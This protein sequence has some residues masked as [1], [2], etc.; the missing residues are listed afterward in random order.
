[1]A[2][3]TV[4]EQLHGF[5]DNLRDA[6]EWVPPKTECESILLCG[7]GGSAI[8]G[9][10]ASEIYM[11]KTKI[12][13][14]TVKTYHIP[15]WA[16]ENTLAIVSSYSGNTLETLKMYEAAKKAGCKIIA[17]TSGGKLKERCDR[18]GYLVKTLPCNMQPR[19]SI[20]F[21]I[22]YTMA[23]LDSCGCTCPTKDKRRVLESLVSYRDYLESADGTAMV[24]K[25][26]DELQD[27]IPAVVSNAYMQSIAVRWKTQ[28]NENSKFVAFC[29]SFSEFDC[30]AIGKWIARG[31]DN[32]TLVT[33]GKF[34][35]PLELEA[36]HI[37]ID[38]GC[39]DPVE[40]A[41]HA[42]MLGDY[43]SMRMAD[44]RGVNAESVAPI[45]SLK[46]K[47]SMMPDYKDDRGRSAPRDP[48]RHLGQ[49]REDA[50]GG[51]GQ[52]RPQAVMEPDVVEGYEP[53][54]P[55]QLVGVPDVLLEMMG[56]KVPPP[57]HATHRVGAYGVL[58]Q[59]L[60]PYDLV[61]EMVSAR[62]LQPYP[63]V[64]LLVRPEPGVE[65]AH[66]VESLLPDQLHRCA[67]EDVLAE[68]GR[69]GPDELLPGTEHAH[70]AMVLD[71]VPRDHHAGSLRH[72]GHLLGDLVGVPLVIVVEEGNPG[73]GAMGGGDVPLVPGEHVP[74][75]HVLYRDGG[76]ALRDLPNPAGYP[77]VE[78][79]IGYDYLRRK[80]GLV[81]RAR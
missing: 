10:I 37:S 43:L 2:E 45:K 35:D 54:H 24:D 26:A 56:E 40:N 9:S 55:R 1:M 46:D 22:G 52:H 66:I 76:I 53:E 65:T 51:E 16:N 42:L 25:L 19:H 44:K 75:R 79:R 39:E 29:G 57:L 4:K 41:L 74:D 12:P 7:M 61:H 50:I 69:G 23:L 78:S 60:P 77:L 8:S 27:T 48:S 73:P 18:D 14:V 3:K 47:L 15:A 13:L 71:L 36:N 11:R 64:P 5:P 6:I 34:N 59:M 31:N 33:I 32:L 28:V 70:D 21:M 68:Y 17:I 30:E 38:S 58:A 62:G 67:A 49:R 20:G 80:E 72:G 63:Q 81:D